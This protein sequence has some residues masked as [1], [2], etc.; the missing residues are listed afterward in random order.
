MLRSWSFCKATVD[1]FV[2]Q[3]HSLAHLHIESHSVC[4]TEYLTLLCSQPVFHFCLYISCIIH[5]NQ[6]S[7][8]IWRISYSL[9]EAKK[10]KFK[11]H[12]LLKMPVLESVK[13]HSP[14]QL[15][16]SLLLILCEDKNSPCS[17]SVRYI[18]YFRDIWPLRMWPSNS[19]RR[20][21][22]ACTL[23]RGPCIGTWCWRPTG[24]CSL[25]VRITFL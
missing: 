5:R 3:D 21:G 1:F 23:L 2:S 14:T 13:T 6:S 11:A 16:L 18:F 8:L 10:L 22:N 9:T 19:L 25:W 20:S 12:N 17:P 15:I 4:T 7:T 24:T